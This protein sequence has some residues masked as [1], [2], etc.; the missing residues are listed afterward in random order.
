MHLHTKNFHQLQITCSPFSVINSP[1][2]TRGISFM[3]KEVSAR[4]FSCVQQTLLSPKYRTEEEMERLGVKQRRHLAVANQ[5]RTTFSNGFS[6][7]CAYCNLLEKDSRTPRFFPCKIDLSVSE[8]G[9]MEGAQ[10]NRVAFYRH[11]NSDKIHGIFIPLCFYHL[12][13]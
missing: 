3:R 9:K 8:T 1:C 11:R 5:W 6:R 10:L 13:L 12:G 7:R 2:F 4:G